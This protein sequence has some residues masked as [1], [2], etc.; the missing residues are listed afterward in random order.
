MTMRVLEYNQ[1]KSSQTMDSHRSG[2][3]AGFTKTKVA[4]TDCLGTKLRRARKRQGFELRSAEQETKVALRH[5][6]ALESGHY[7]LLPAPVYVRG[8][9]TRYAA[10]L[11]LKAES[12]LADYDREYQTYTRVRQ[13][14]PSKHPQEGMLRP[15]VA[16]DVL[17]WRRQWFVTPEIIWGSA[18]SVA[19]VGVLG[20][21]WFQVASFAA[22]P[23]LDI[24]TPGS[25]TVVSAE[26]V[27]IAGVTDPGASLTINSQVVAVT[28][29][30]HFRQAVRLSSGVNTIEIAATN[31]SDKATTKVLQL[32]VNLPQVAGPVKPNSSSNHE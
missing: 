5:L 25:Q 23:P 15:H 17:R 14:R 21:I 11:G 26:Q 12:V 18:L 28:A 19:L 29:E 1:E 7:H 27:E 13:V 6:E 10:Y 3:G 30:G 32:L 4:S 9:L 24:V 31:Q 22:A 20:Y 16:D 8:F 2:R